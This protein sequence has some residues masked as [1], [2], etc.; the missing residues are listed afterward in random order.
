MDEDLLSFDDITGKFVMEVDQLGLSVTSP[1]EDMIRR[2]VIYM[3]LKKI[4]V[5]VDTSSNDTTLTTITAEDIQVSDQLK[6]EMES[7]Y[8]VPLCMTTAGTAANPAF[9]AKF[10]TLSKGYGLGYEMTQAQITVRD[11][12]LYLDEDMLFDFDKAV[13]GGID[14]LFSPS[15]MS[16]TTTHPQTFVAEHMGMRL[17]FSPGQLT[18]RQLRAGEDGDLIKVIMK[19]KPAT[20]TGGLPN[21]DIVRSQTKGATS[22]MM[23]RVPEFRMM[24]QETSYTS[25]L[26]S[27]LKHTSEGLLNDFLAAF[28]HKFARERSQ[29]SAFASGLDALSCSGRRQLIK[30]YALGIVP[31]V[32]MPPRSRAPRVFGLDQSLQIYS[33]DSIEIDGQALLSRISGRW[34]ILSAEKYVIHFEGLGS[35]CLVTN[36]NLLVITNDSFSLLWECPLDNI[37]EVEITLGRTLR[38]LDRE[39]ARLNAINTGAHTQGDSNHKTFECEHLGV[40]DSLRSMLE[41]YICSRIMNA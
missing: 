25:I 23:L 10:S 4:F 6:G 20:R 21:L 7:A 8:Q 1:S 22:E 28:E 27:V 24:D 32:G 15:L 37:D 16:E 2:E 31:L 19:F 9:K 35:W 26:M 14:A 18:V 11:I 17:G 41:W 13:L 38:V 39:E 40:L 12:V 3:E 34:S 36:R 33:R 30:P 29:G 5:T